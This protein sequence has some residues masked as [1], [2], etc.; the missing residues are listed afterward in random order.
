M[1]TRMIRLF[2]KLLHKT[3]KRTLVSPFSKL[4]SVLFHP[5]SGLR[6]KIKHLYG[7]LNT[8]RAIL[9][10]M[11]ISLVSIISSYLNFAS[12]P[13]PTYQCQPTATRL[14]PWDLHPLLPLMFSYKLELDC[15]V[16]VARVRGFSYCISFLHT[17]FT[18]LV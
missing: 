14:F 13:D 11:L 9:S 12:F 16:N 18:T 6:D 15:S 17:L 2:A 4:I 8:F 7:T 10:G 3:Q 1:S 5:Q